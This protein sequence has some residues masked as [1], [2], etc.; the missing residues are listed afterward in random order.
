[1]QKRKMKSYKQFLAS[2]EGYNN[3]DLYSY[4][5][6]PKYLLCDKELTPAEKILWI[7]LASFLYTSKREIFPSR[8][9]LSEVLGIK[10]NTSISRMTRKLQDKGYLE[11]FFLSEINRV[12]Y[13]PLFNCKPKN[14]PFTESIYLAIPEASK[15]NREGARDG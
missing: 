8:K 15:Y 14:D 2:V 9:R 12:Y 7:S 5:K 10:N 11:K 13:D 3:G 4:V 1:M 6:V